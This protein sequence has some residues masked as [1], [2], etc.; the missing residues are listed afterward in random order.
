MDRSLYLAYPRGV[1]IYSEEL[2][3]TKFSLS[4]ASWSSFKLLE[5]SRM[6]KDIKLKK[7]SE[8]LILGGENGKFSF[9]RYI[10]LLR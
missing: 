1:V 10:T 5:N 3:F 4:Y 2:S 6:I 8:S 9:Y 7:V